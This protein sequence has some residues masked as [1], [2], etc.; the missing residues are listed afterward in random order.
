[1]P[2]SNRRSKAA[3]ELLRRDGQAALDW[4]AQYLE[5][6]PELPVLSQAKPG[7]ILR[8]LPQHAPQQP[9]SFDAILN[10]LDSSILPG[11]THWQSPNYFAYF[12]ANSSPAS[13]AGDLLS[14][15]L[16][17]Q[18]MLWTTSPACTELE[19]R[20]LDW[21]V[22][23]LALPEHFL[24]TQSGGGVIQDSASS[25]NL[26]AVLAGRERA[27]Q[28]RSNEEGC[29]QRLRAY[30]SS[31]AHS[32][33][34]K[35][36]KVAGIGR[37]NLRLIEVDDQF[38]MK[39]SHL[40]RAVE[41]DK[42]EGRIPCFVGATVGT[43]S[44]M[45]ID[46]LLEI[47]AICREHGIWLHVDAAMAG[48]A[49]LCDELRY[50]HKGLEYAD[51]YCFD[52]HKWMLTNFDCT[53]F[54][55]RDRNELTDALTI[56]PEYLRNTA[57]ASGTV[58]DYR[59]WH[60]PLGR[61]FRALKLWCVIR[62]YG[63]EGLRAMVRRHVQLTNELASWLRSDSR[64]EIVAPVSLNLVCFRLK[65]PDSA[66]EA[67]LHKL[68]ASGRLFLSHTKLNGKFVL[69]FCIGQSYTDQENVGAAWHEIQRHATEP[70]VAA[71]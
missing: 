40:A 62:S 22:E 44:T 30:T 4:V 35:A 69:R 34:E 51:S 71:G 27:T 45:S 23:M 49:A 20:V 11:I 36:V 58:V 38:G 48:T 42:R 6:A 24:S 70:A 21:L 16:G 43:T 33:I 18:G 10:D 65:G 8:S 54:Y 39:A 46:P 28:F 64:F 60:I 63:L 19:M 12:P 13:V 56:T 47:G 17:V 2:L 61:R 59:D 5:H 53:C 55:V 26:C 1:M 31:Q 57:S 14:S 25:A 52:C 67:L 32:S 50:I 9:E 68:N 29:D 7:D 15:G 3:A 41:Q 66:N 37:R